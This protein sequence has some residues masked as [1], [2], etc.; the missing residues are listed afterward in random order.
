MPVVK[1]ARVKKTSSGEEEEEEEDE[2]SSEEHSGSDEV[3]VRV[4]VYV[5][6]CVC[7]CVY[8]ACELES[9]KLIFRTLRGF[10]SWLDLSA[11][12]RTTTEAYTRACTHAQ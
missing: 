11:R 10:N 5:C 7:M 3:C 2:E 8:V 9:T 1:K 4:C 12:T 6:V